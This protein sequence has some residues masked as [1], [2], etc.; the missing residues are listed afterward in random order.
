MPEE[1]SVSARE[2]AYTVALS[3]GDNLPTQADRLPPGSKSPLGS[4]DGRSTYFTTLAGELDTKACDAA[5]HVCDDEDGPYAN[6]TET[7]CGQCFW[8][9]NPHW[10]VDL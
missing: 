2:L 10:C 4:D 1:I 8:D 5:R 9:H 6:H 7:D 3:A